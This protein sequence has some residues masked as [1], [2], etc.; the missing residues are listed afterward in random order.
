M[1]QIILNAK[2]IARPLDCRALTPMALQGKTADEIAALPLTANLKVGDA[3][4]VSVDDTVAA[5][6]LVMHH[7]GAQHHYI[8]FAMQGGTLTVT[9]QAGDFLGAQMQQGVLLCHGHAGD[10]VGDRMRRGLLLIDG[11]VGAYC[12]SDMQAGTLGV[13]GRTGDYLGYGMRRGTVLLAQAPKLTATWSDCGLHS[14]PFLK[15][16][17]QSFKP[18]N[19]QFAKVNTLRVQRWMGDM[20]SLGKGEILWLQP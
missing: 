12:A 2:A 19:S 7:T 14:L 4:A 3:F 17:Y 8:G 13:L 15:L 5:A 18:L 1:S 9:A 11:D 20:G 16:L 6:E 10:R